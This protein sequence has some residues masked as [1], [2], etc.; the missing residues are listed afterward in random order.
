M[1]PESAQLVE[2]AIRI[3][4]S[5]AL[6]ALGSLM[7][8]KGTASATRYVKAVPGGGAQDD[9]NSGSRPL[10]VCLF[11]LP[12]WAVTFLGIIMTCRNL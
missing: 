1:S 3:S 6:I 7:V 11:C 4:A 5:L 12:G 10:T 8:A 9:E 2:V